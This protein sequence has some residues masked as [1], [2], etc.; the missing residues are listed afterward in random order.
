MAI[1]RLT[2][3]DEIMLWADELWPQDIGGLAVLEGG[4]LF[5]AEGRLRIEDLRAAIAARLHL[6]PRFRQLLCVPP[7][8]QGGPFWVDA[9]A[10]DVA[11]HVHVLEVRPPGGE[12]EL[13]QAAEE[14]VSQGLDRSRPLW[15]MWFLSG[16][17]DG[18]VGWL[19]K[20]HHCVADGIAGVATFATFVDASPDVIDT[21]PQAWTPAPAPTEADLFA[22]HQRRRQ[23]QRRERLSSF[24]H[25]VRGLR[26]LGSVWPALRELF[27]EPALPETSLDRTVGAGRRLVFVRSDLE[28]ARQ[29]AH[30]SG[31]KV[32]DVLLAATAGGLRSL[33][34]SRGEPV[35]TEV[36]VYV[37][38]T[39]RPLDQRAQARG[40]QIAQMV[41][42]IPLAEPDAVKR[43]RLIGAETAR[44]KTRAR[45]SIGKLPHRGIAGRM[46]LKLIDRQRVNV[47]TADLLGPQVPLYL[48]GARL[49]EVFPVLPLIGKVSLGVGA[50]SYA[51]QFNIAV[52]ADLDAYPDLEVFAAGVRRELRTLTSAPGIKARGHGVAASKVGP[53]ADA[54]G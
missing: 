4:G 8:P 6:L 10:F 53:A 52:V 30:A 47:T 38:V 29:I 16:L 3:E 40:N 37:P 45:P 12:A 18:R 41:V 51:G 13:A 54:R 32:N 17:K 11:R 50:L 2:A 19:V 44:R 49:L 23:A 26:H 31:A 5:D 35:G 36:R 7:R 42:P 46:L 21:S 15:D 27:A 28:A 1:E 39:L 20:L 34:Q 33:L 48:A 14:L 22:D 43:L 24:V 25:G 9:P